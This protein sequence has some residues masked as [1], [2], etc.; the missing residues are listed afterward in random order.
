MG[1]DGS[2]K[3]WMKRFVKGFKRTSGGVSEGQPSAASFHVLFPL[4]RPNVRHLFHFKFSFLVQGLAVGLDLLW[5]T[6]GPMRKRA[7]PS[8]HGF[9]F[10]TEPVSLFTAS[11]TLNSSPV[12][13]RERL[14]VFSSNIKKAKHSSNT[15]YNDMFN[16][17]SGT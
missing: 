7:F 3:I 17:R 8:D 9:G 1:G 2:K 14:D 15:Y 16:I 13:I 5:G 10:E 12:G 6:D 11:V 4:A